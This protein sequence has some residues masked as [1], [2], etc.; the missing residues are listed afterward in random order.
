[1]SLPEPD[2]ASATPA[3]EARDVTRVFES[4]DGGTIPVL[5]RIDL[6]VH[7]G[8]SIA[9]VGPSG[10][11]KSTLLHLL[12]ALDRPTTGDIRLAGRGVSTLTDGELAALRNEHVGFVFQFHH[13]LRDFT[14]VENVMVPQLVAGVPPEVAHGRALDLL[15]QVGLVPRA[16][17]RPGKLSGGEQ[18]RVAVARALANDPPLVLADEPSGNLDAEATRRLHDLLFEL[19]ARHGTALVVVT[20]SR[21][22]AARAGVTLRI[23]GGEL[24]V[25]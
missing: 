6:A 24:T 9:I 3:V 17:H 11:G 25:T 12:G 4:P 2:R 7:P 23:E 16:S 1:M 14:A 19:L 18:Q 15:D 13:L 5:R 8:E 22:L 20:H 10:S 21:E